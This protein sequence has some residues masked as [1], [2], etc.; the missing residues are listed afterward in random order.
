MANG[1]SGAELLA[2]ADLLLATE[3]PDD[4]DDQTVVTLPPDAAEAATSAELVTVPDDD[5]APDAKGL[6]ATRGDFADSA[7]SDLPPDLNPARSYLRRLTSENSRTVQGSALRSIAALL[8]QGRQPPAGRSLLDAFPWVALR[9]THTT[10]VRARLAAKQPNT[11]KAYAPTSANRMLAALKGVIREA[12]RLGHIDAEQMQR[13]T[14]VPGV[15]GSRV[16]KGR[17]LPVAEVMAVS[18]ACDLGTVKGARDAAIL[19]CMFACALRRAEVCELNADSVT[20]NADGGAQLVVMGKGNKERTVPITGGALSAVRAWLRLRETLHGQPGALFCPMR[21]GDRPQ[22]GSRMSP[23]SVR[24]IAKALA[25][26]AGV[27]PFNPHDGR[28]TAATDMIDAGADLFSVQKV[29]GHASVKTTQ[30]Y[31]LR[32]ERAKV[33]AVGRIDFPYGAN[34]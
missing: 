9:Y 22:W 32:G 8:L 29:L 3:A 11:G 4:D 23:G 14:D 28:R 7:W 24:V 34:G 19:A 15:K 27:A 20:T 10:A 26:A 16:S 21:K 1:S 30:R 31:D 25:D 18:N 13:A 6:V 33:D 12:W 2:A 5:G 17:R